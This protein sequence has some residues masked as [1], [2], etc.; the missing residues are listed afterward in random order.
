METTRLLAIAEGLLVGAIWASSP[1]IVKMG[2]AH[3]GPLTLAGMRYFAAFLVLLPL[4][5]RCGGLRSNPAPGHWTRLFLMGL[6]NYTIGNG[7]LFWGLQYLPATTVSFLGSLIP[8]LVLFLAIIWLR[9]MPTRRQVMGL[10][11]ALG[12]AL[13]SSPPD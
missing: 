11:V 4:M 7:T 8:L 2:L 1:V 10:L 5:A 6:C 3:M 13:S 12:G 9:E